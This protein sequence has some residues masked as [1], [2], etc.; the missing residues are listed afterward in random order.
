MSA[1]GGSS[2]LTQRPSC[3]SPQRTMAAKGCKYGLYDLS[4]VVAIGHSEQWRPKAAKLPTKLVKYRQLATLVSLCCSCSCSCPSAR[5]PGRS[6]TAHGGETTLQTVPVW[7]DDKETIGRKNLIPQ[8][9][10]NFDKSINK[11]LF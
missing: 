4:S 1:D 7:D 3:C 5:G 9:L 6:H 11:Y 8:F 10:R 2:S